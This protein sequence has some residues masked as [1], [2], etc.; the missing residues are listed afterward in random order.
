MTTATAETTRNDYPIC[1]YC[2]YHLV[3]FYP[4]DRPE[5]ATLYCESGECK[6]RS[7]SGIMNGY[8]IH[9][10]DL[11]STYHRCIS[12]RRSWWR[13]LSCRIGLWLIGR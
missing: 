11:K 1:P 8:D 3:G 2:G 4:P 5:D 12:P 9:L 13:K 6:G 10:Y 7:I